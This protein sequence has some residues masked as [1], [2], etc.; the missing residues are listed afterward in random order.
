MLNIT[1]NLYTN[2]YD[3]IDNGKWYTSKLRA[4]FNITFLANM[5]CNIYKIYIIS[6]DI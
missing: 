6:N 1:V 3:F 5:I 2:L 4:R